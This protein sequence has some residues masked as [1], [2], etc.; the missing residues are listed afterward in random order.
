MFKE[1]IIILP[2][3]TIIKMPIYREYLTHIL[4]LTFIDPRSSF[5]IMNFSII[6]YVTFHLS[7]SQKTSATTNTSKD[8]SKGKQNL[9]R[10]INTMSMNFELG[11]V[12]LL[13]IYV[14][15]V[16]KK[17]PVCLSGLISMVQRNRF[18]KVR[19]VLKTTYSYFHLSTRKSQFH[20]SITEKIR[21]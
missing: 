21:F 9:G 4:G 3:G 14:Q 12:N 16:P 19:P 6:T 11:F 7:A 2:Y 18:G 17:K 20:P 8:R 5:I 10:S 15:G 1:K 13:S